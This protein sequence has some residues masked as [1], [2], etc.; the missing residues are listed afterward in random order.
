MPICGASQK[1]NAKL[2]SKHYTS[3]RKTLVN[4]NYFN[5]GEIWISFREVKV[6]LRNCKRRVGKMQDL[7]IPKTKLENEILFWA[8]DEG[9]S[10]SGK[11]KAPKQI[12]DLVRRFERN[13]PAYKSR[14]YKETQLREEFINPFF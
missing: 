1:G 8:M 13:L 5:R 2:L 3:K 6:I 12:I 11:E 7:L 14:A 4:Y 9:L 10:S